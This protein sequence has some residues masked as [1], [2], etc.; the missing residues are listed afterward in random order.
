MVELVMAKCPRC[1]ADLHLKPG[2]QM[3]S[4]EY[5]NSEVMVVD[6]PAGNQADDHAE[7]ENRKLGLELSQRELTEVQS[8]AGRL[9]P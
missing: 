4:C 2:Q 3:F 5:C 9:S 8:A 1:G 6:R 7:I